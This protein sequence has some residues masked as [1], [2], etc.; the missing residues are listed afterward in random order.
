MTQ[1]YLTLNKISSYTKSFALSDCVWD[2][3]V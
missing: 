3:V 2:I 1:E